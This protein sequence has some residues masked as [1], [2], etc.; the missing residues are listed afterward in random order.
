MATLVNTTTG[1]AATSNSV[2]CTAFAT[3]SDN[4]IVV[5]VRSTGTISSVSDTAGNT[6]TAVAASTFVA[7]IGNLRVFYAKNI[8]G[9]AS[10]VITVTLSGGDFTGIVAH[11]Y[12]GLHT[13]SPLDTHTIKTSAVNQTSITSDAWNIVQSGVIFGFATQNANPTYTAG[14]NYILSGND[15]SNAAQGEYRINL[16]PITGE[17]TSM[18]SS[19]SANWILWGVAFKDAVPFVPSSALMMGQAF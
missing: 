16:T 2:A 1:S 5:G 13:T 17:T 15:G 19:A 6:Y 14:S 12:S 4:L 10:N 8:T 7:A 11:Q 18:S 9:N 3:T